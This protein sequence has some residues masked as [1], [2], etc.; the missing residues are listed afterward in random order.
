M[1][2]GEKGNDAGEGGGTTGSTTISRAEGPGAATTKPLCDNCG[3][4]MG[5]GAVC[6]ACGWDNQL[7]RPEQRNAGSGGNARVGEGEAGGSITDESGKM[8]DRKRLKDRE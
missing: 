1:T 7:G 3:A 4:R 2:V 8:G 5:T 6:K